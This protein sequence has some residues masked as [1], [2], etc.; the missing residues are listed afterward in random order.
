LLYNEKI[1]FIHLPAYNARYNDR[2]EGLKEIPFGSESF[3]L[4]FLNS[5]FSHMLSRDVIFYLNEF[6][7]CLRTDGY[8][9]ITAFVEEN[10]PDEVENPEN[11]L[12]ESKGALHRVR[13]N[14]E[15]FFK[16]IKDTGF[17]V[18]KFYHQN[19]TR[20]KQSVIVLK[21]IDN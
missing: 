3:G 9:Y 11:Y 7:K 19:I 6:Y 14:K 12:A 16:I 4:I 5:V 10:V 2:V 21:K 17:E 13:F 8:I 18:C 1:S 20:T 15:Y